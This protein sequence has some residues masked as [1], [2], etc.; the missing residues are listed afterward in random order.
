MTLNELIMSADLKKKFNHIYNYERFIGSSVAL[1]VIQSKPIGIWEFLIPIVFIL[2]FMRN[3]QSRELFIQNYM[4]TKRHALDAAFKMLKKGLSQE[5]VISGVEEK[6]RAL[7][8]A[9]ETQGIYSDTIRQQQMDEIELLFDHYG[10]LL[11]VEGGDY[12]ALA[13]N[14]YGSRPN[15]V[16]FHEQLKSAEKKVSDAARQTLGSKADV[17]ALLRIESAT[18]DVR[19]LRIEKIFRI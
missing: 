17:E 3:K 13:R 5:D 12:D 6:T 16:I 15:Y 10:R 2:H 1:R 18:E 19:Q 11:G 4:F 7:L 14:A 8:T 9:P